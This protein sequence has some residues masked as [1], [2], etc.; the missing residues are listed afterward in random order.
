MNTLIKQGVSEII[1]CGSNFEFVLNDNTQIVS[2][3]Y[4]VLQSSWNEYFVPCMTLLYNGKNAIYYAVNNLVPLSSVI[5]TLNPINYI[6]IVINVM[7]S[8]IAIK[9]NGFINEN[10]ILPELENVYIDTQTLNVKLVSLP[11]S[12]ASESNGTVFENTIKS[13]LASEVEKNNCILSDVTKKLMEDLQNPRMDIKDIL[14]H[15][16]NGSGT[17]KMDDAD[18]DNAY[19]TIDGFDYFSDSNKFYSNKPNNSNGIQLVGIAPFDNLKFEISKA[20]Y[21]IGKKAE[22]VDGVIPNDKNVSRKHCVIH[23][24]NNSYYITDE[25]SLNGT[26]IN[27]KRISSGRIMQLNDG[28]IVKLADVEFRVVM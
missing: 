26:Y 17:S 13:N 21:V 5:E 23:C 7:N 3:E 16:V 4:K 28:D 27:G 20:E 2:T 15:Y 18:I 12:A 9:D 25:E 11:I 22:I 14:D 8:I 24:D 10:S 1:K 6:D 19:T